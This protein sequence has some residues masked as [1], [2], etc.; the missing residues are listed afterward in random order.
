MGLIKA[1]K[2]AVSSMLADQWRE[3]F[4]CDSLSNDILAAKGRKRQ[5]GGRNSNK[6]G[7]NIISNGSI[8]AVNEGQCMM[9]VEQGGIAEFCAEA[10][11]FVYDNSTEPSLFYGDLGENLKGT[12]QAIGKRF[13]FGGGAGKDQRVY[14]FNTKEI[15]DNRYGTATPIPFRYIDDNIGLDMDVTIRC[16][17]SYS[18]RIVDPLL[19]YQNVCG[20]VPDVYSRSEIQNQMKSE[21]M[22]A[23]QPA[24]GKVSSLR[25]R[26]SDIPS[27]VMELVDAR[28]PYSSKN[29]DMD[30][31]ARNKKR[32]ILLNKCDLADEKATDIWQTY[33]E[34]R[35]FCVIRINALKGSGMGGV[36]EAAKGLMKEK[37]E[38]LKARGRINVPIRSMVVGIP[39]VGKSTFINKYVGKATAKT[40]DKPGVTRGKQWIK[41]KKDF[42]LLDTPGILW[43]KFED[44]QV[45]LKLAFTGAINDDILDAET[46]GAAFINHMAARDADCLRRRYQVDF[47]TIDEPHEI[48]RR[49]AEAR[50]FKLKGG[51]PDMERAAKILLDEFRG[52]KLG[53]LT[54]ELPEDIAEQN[55]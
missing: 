37:I 4:Y 30:T 6:G 34:A 40:G 49:I 36:T 21:L 45:G 32:M 1:A 46:L 52:G 47:D 16:N 15:M 5:S 19:F 53:R 22:T 9:I 24:L 39:N 35:G 38:K 27:H 2:D 55:E 3:Y 8:I 41:L 31:L 26:V 14:F 54:L 25:V 28:I 42:E 7:D 29:P 12:F 23:M 33:F 17:G 10:G 43:P 50:G 18:F 13:S 48:L 51:E 20:N 11:E 44:Q